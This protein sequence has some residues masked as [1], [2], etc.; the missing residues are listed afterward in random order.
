MGRVVK[1][2]IYAIA[3]LALWLWFSSIIKS[4]QAPKADIV[5]LPGDTFD[6]DD[7]ADTLARE[8]SLF[9][10]EEEDSTLEDDFQETSYNNEEEYEEIDYSSLDEQLDE[11]EETTEPSP[12][13]TQTS[14]STYTSSTGNYMI[15]CGSYLVKSNATKMR[16]RLSNMGYDSEIVQFDGSEFHSV[17]AQRY[18]SHSRAQDISRKLKQAGIDNYVHRRKN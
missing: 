5:E 10:D 16:D 13:S 6:F 11:P 18:D 17:S 3:I 7:S 15:I 14:N 9:E 12:T 1:I 2:I 4:C 8:E